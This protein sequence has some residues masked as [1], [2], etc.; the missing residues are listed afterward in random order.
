VTLLWL[1]RALHTI[2]PPIQLNGFASSLKRR[3]LQ[4]YF[5]S[6]P[7]FSQLING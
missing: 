2:A 7:Y 1:K 6:I 3:S 4:T 5:G